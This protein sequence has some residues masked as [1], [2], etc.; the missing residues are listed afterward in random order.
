MENALPAGAAPAV[1]RSRHHP[2]GRGALAVFAAAYG[3]VLPFA[4]LPLMIAALSVALQGGSV[5]PFLVV[6]FPLA[7]AG[8]ALWTG[9]AL[10]R[11]VV[12]VEA[13]PQGVC[14]RTAWEAARDAPRTWDAIHGLRYGI[15]WI[16]FA[17]GRSAV[18]LDETDWPDAPRLLDTL[19]FH[20]RTIYELPG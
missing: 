5:R 3:R 1:F 12:E 8:A 18:E 20:A 7:F 19:R 9:L 11:R 4:L 2:E 10:G 15:P 17:W 6:F 16:T 14:L 13:G